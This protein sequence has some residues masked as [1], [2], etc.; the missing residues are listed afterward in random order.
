MPDQVVPPLP[1]LVEYR[2][3]E[4]GEYRMA[5][6][7]TS[8]AEPDWLEFGDDYPEQMAERNRLLAIRRADVL[9]CQPEA[10]P[11]A[12]E[13]LQTLVDHLCQHHPS[14]FTSSGRTLHNHLLDERIHLDGDHPLAI[15]GR[16][17]QED[18]CLNQLHADGHRLT[19]AILCF[20]TRWS[21]AEKLGKPLIRV[22]EHVP[23]FESRLGT[24]V[25]RFFTSLKTG[26]MAQRLNWSIIDDDTLFQVTGKGRT[27]LDSA[28]SPANALQRLYLRVERQSFRRL[29]QSQAVVFGIR[30]H[31][32]RLDI[33]SAHPGEA[34]RLSTALRALP[35]DMTRYKSVYRFSAALQTA[36]AGLV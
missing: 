30:I 4:A 36:L 26:R 13:L 17:V 24:P 8:V 28:I 18:F 10:E 11:A 6:G 25:E 22:H 32:T 16:L 15:A 31:Q 3:Y 27:D 34:A 12:A 2:P 5:M 23:Q 35:D 19:G 21:L 33:V 20:P 29:P 7:L 1:K 9:A 14:W